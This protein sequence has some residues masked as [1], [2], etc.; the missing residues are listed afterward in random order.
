M[1]SK[2]LLAL[3]ATAVLALPACRK[4]DQTN[5]TATDTTAASAT[6]DTVSGTNPASPG[7]TALVPQTAAGT[8]VIV[9][10]NDGSIAVTNADAIPPGPAVF[11]V[12]NGGKNVHN[13]FIEGPGVSKAAGNDMSPGATQNVSV[14]LQPGKYLLYCP[15]LDHKQKGESVDLIIKPANAPAP[16]S[17]AVP[18][19]ATD[20]VST[21]GTSTTGTVTG[22]SGG[23]K[24]TGG[25]AKKSG[26]K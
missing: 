6:S 24:T 14:T 4:E 13:L 20:T 2:F 18:A 1:R 19:S 26:V 25:K 3:L 7:G 23:G 12:T 8:T 5:T 15:I 10:L 22:T 11:T 21:A 16:S 17:T 9:A